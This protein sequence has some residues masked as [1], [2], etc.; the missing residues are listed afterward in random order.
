[1]PKTRTSERRV[2]LIP[3]LADELRP[4]QKVGQAAALKAGKKVT[5]EDW[6]W[7]TEEGT[8]LRYSN[9]V[10]RV[11]NRIQALAEI[12]QRSPHDL[13]HTWASQMLAAGAGPAWVARQL[14]HSSPLITLRIYA[15]WVPGSKRVSADVLDGKPD[16][17]T[18]R[19]RKRF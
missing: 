8:P 12:R 3:R 4:W 15:H 1:M 6:I 5:A 14:G 19:K 17:Q 2:D 7:T 9:W 11:W 10:R 18:T 16:T 13:R